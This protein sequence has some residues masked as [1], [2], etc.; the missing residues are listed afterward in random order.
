M[1]TIRRLSSL[2][3]A[4]VCVAAVLALV[5]GVALASAIGSSGTPP[6][7]RSLAIAVHRA[8]AAGA[9]AGVTARIKPRHNAGLLGGAELAWDALRGVPLRVAIY[10]RGVATPVL[11]LKVTDISYGPVPAS[12]FNVSAPNGA[13]LHTVRIPRHGRDRAERP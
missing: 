11:E 7:R 10:A 6:P 12:T 3:L 1:S 8:L 5:G 13:R 9:P 2:Q 4:A